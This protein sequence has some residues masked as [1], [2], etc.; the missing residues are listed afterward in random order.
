MEPALKSSIPPFGIWSTAGHNPAPVSYFRAL[1]LLHRTFSQYP[2]SV[3]M[4]V[5]GRFL[6]CPFLRLLDLVQPGMR[7][8][9]IGSG[10]GT[11]A[12]L[13]AAVGAGPVIGVEPDLRKILDSYREKAVHFVAGFD[14]A[15]G[16]RFDLIT[17]F[18]V[19]YRVPV[20]EWDPLFARIHARL[21]PGGM[22]LIK[23]LDPE[24]RAK[25][26]WNR[27]QEW[28]SDRFLKLTIGSAFSYESRHEMEAR[29]LRAGF[30][31][32]DV[33]EIDAGYPHSHV[34]YIARTA[35]A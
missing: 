23:E 24:N 3:R 16:G 19:L 12:R 14:E 35:G 25:F 17:M 6:T 1:L 31:A 8:L 15:I 29:L 11:F 5:L 4:H 9:D 21:A 18:D 10:H 26:A 7:L 30:D 13:A 22:L 34:A 2:L 33:R 28:V 20:A 27:A 32:V